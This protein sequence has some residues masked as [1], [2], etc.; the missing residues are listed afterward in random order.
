[1]ESH[2]AGSSQ[3]GRFGAAR[4]AKQEEDPWETRKKNIIDWTLC[5]S[6]Q[7]KPNMD[8]RKCKV[9]VDREGKLMGLKKDRLLDGGEGKQKHSVNIFEEKGAQRG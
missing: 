7:R 6:E 3:G 4:D 9:P 2:T 1:M 8:D 5:H